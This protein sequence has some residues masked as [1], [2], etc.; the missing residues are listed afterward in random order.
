MAAGRSLPQSPLATIALVVIFAGAFFGAGCS[1]LLDLEPCESDSDCPDGIACSDDGLCED[2]EILNNANFNNQPECV[3]NDACSGDQICTDEGQ[4]EALPD[5]CSDDDAC[6]RGYRCT[7]ANECQAAPD[8]CSE[9]SDCFEGYLCGVNDRCINASAQCEEDRDCRPLFGD[10]GTCEDGLCQGDTELVGGPCDRLYGAAGEDDAILFGV[11]VQ[12]SGVGAGFGQPMLDAARIAARDINN[13]G[14]IDGRQVG[15]VACDTQA[16]NATAFEAA[17]HLVN[18]AGAHGI[19]GLNSSQTLDIAPGLTIPEQ[20]LLM[21]PSATAQAITYLE[22]D[23]LVWRT[24]PSDEHQA[25]ALVNLV[26][27]LLTDHLA[28]PEAE[29]DPSLAILRR[30]DDQWATGLYD[31]LIGQLPADLTGDDS[32]FNSYSFANVGTGESADY[33]DVAAEIAAQDVHPDLIVV[34]GSADS[35]QIIEQ[36]DSLLE[37]PLFVGADAMKN[38]EE[39]AKAPAALEGRIWGTGP[40]TAAALNYQPY[41]IFRL[42][43]EEELNADADNFQFVAN[44]FDA[45]YTMAFASASAMAGE[46]D[47]T[48]CAD[49]LDCPDD[50]ICEAETCVADRSLSGP[51]LAQGLAQLAE[52]DEIRPSSS[53]AGQAIDTLLSGGTINYAGASGAINF[54]DAGDPEPMPIALWCFEDGQVPERGEL[55]TVDGGFTPLTCGDEPAQ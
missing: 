41:T 28:D 32:R 30:R 5:F 22:D 16:S 52:G 47:G 42:K 37:D 11:V 48:A 15:L 34:L 6:P 46:D 39:A 45:L 23:D 17:D 25:V 55:Y 38:L 9:D 14:G 33:T 50:Q 20:T 29:A 53:D 8:D 44:A 31:E 21:S 27:Y 24:A 54:N 12:L 36:I 26:D 40:R 10:S 19:I 2:E 1:A 43:F 49:N 3:S 35:W 13:L 4:C 7:M 51:N 18:T